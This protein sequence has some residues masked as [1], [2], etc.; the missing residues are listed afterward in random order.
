MNYSFI[1]FF[2][3]FLFFLYLTE[4]GNQA[5]GMVLKNP[6]EQE[7]AKN[8]AFEAL[9]IKCNFCHATKKKT[10]VFTLQNMDSLAPDIFEQVFVKKRMPRGKKSKLSTDER[11]ALERWLSTVVNAPEPHD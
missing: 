2:A 9:Q 6:L 1:S 10:D 7:A 5:H 11:K 8:E 4:V 3:L